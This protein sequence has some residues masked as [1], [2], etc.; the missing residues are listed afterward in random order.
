MNKVSTWASPR[1]GQS[2]VV[3]N[4]INYIK[5]SERHLNAPCQRTDI[6]NDPKTKENYEA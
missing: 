4:Q 3:P 5:K 6:P 1:D 2:S